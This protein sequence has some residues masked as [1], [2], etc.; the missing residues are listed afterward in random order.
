M[1]EFIYDILVY[2]LDQDKN[3]EHLGIILQAL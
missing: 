3:K 2:S 1:I